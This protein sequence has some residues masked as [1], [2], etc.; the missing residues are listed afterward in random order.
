MTSFLKAGLTS[1]YFNAV[2]KVELDNDL[3]KLWCMKKA[4]MSLFSLITFTGISF[5]WDVF[6]RSYFSSSFNFWSKDVYL[7]EEFGLSNFEILPLIA[8]K[9]E[10]FIYFKIAASTGSRI[11]KWKPFVFSLGKLL[12][13]TVSKYLTI[14]LK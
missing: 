8:I 12:L 11:F 10:W 7:R 5:S 13:V 9:V 14:L 4:T 6:F 3:L 1:S 2:G